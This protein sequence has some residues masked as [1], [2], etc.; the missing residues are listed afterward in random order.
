LCVIWP[1]WIRV[2]GSTT[3]SWPEAAETLRPPAVS[4]PPEIVIP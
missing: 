2:P 3:A 1:D 4:W